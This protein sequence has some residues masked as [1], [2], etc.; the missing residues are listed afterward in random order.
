MSLT[1]DRSAEDASDLQ[2]EDFIEKESRR[3]LFQ[4]RFFVSYQLPTSNY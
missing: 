2:L 3:Q 4:V 1:V